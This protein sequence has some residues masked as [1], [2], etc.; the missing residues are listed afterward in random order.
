ME[1]T[2][3]GLS[4]GLLLVVSGCPPHSASDRSVTASDGVRVACEAVLRAREL[5]LRTAKPYYLS[6]TDLV[7]TAGPPDLRTRMADLPELIKNDWKK[8]PGYT[9][10]YL[11][12][13]MRKFYHAY[14]S[15]IEDRGGQVDPNA[16]NWRRS[17]R[18]N[19]LKVW[20]Y[21][22]ETGPEI[23][24]YGGLFPLFGRGTGTFATTCF[25]I[26]DSRVLACCVL[27]RPLSSRPNGGRR[28]VSNE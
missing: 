23:R 21:R 2:L 20:F 26:D 6:E 19:N 7:D 1:R 5:S 9:D 15:A 25:I 8:K 27:G 16:A 10:Y 28:S 24:V 12:L 4:L 17:E 13:E 22:F 11:D 18:F 14:R 3:L